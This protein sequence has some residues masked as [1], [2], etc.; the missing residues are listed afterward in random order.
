MEKDIARK[1]GGITFDI[2][3]EQPE[4]ILQLIVSTLCGNPA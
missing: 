4:R 3:V 2:F 1:R